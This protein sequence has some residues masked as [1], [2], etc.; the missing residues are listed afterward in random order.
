[1]RGKMREK[2][3]EEEVKK[4]I[5][6]LHGDEI[7]LIKYSGD[8]RNHSK[9]ECMIC[10]YIWDT[11]AQVVCDKRKRGCPSCANKKR[12]SYHKYSFD[13]VKNYIE[14]QNCELVSTEYKNCDN[15]LDIQFVCGHINP[16]SFYWF[17]RGVRCR[18]CGFSFGANSRRRSVEEIHQFLD[19]NNIIFISFP[20]GY[21]NRKSKIVVLCKGCGNPITRSIEKLVVS[22]GF[23]RVCIFERYSNE[24]IGHNGSNWQGGK[25]HLRSFLSKQIR[26][27]KIKSAK[28]Y[29]YL[30]A[31][32]GDSFQCVHH[33]YPFSYILKETL[34]NLGY[35][36]RLSGN[37]SL[38][39]LKFIV[40]EFIRL[41]DVYPLGIP[42]TKKIHRLFHNVF[43]LR[44]NTPSQFYEFV[45]KIRSGEIQIPD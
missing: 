40:I 39:E 29:N 21:Q 8:M 9:F 33:L 35:T 5:F 7:K 31:I 45:E 23:C 11:S 28:E 3:K 42:L 4:R 1:M 44:N 13:F 24:R 22:T 30:C 32:T 14:S 20:N 18:I 6:L 2:I 41:H 36:S 27:W 43:G 38:D 19:K 26:D 25:T 16:L 10:E 12:G 37:Y 15:L 17:Q 34:D